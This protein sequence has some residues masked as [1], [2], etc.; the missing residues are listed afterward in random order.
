MKY[1]AEID[2]QPLEIEVRED[3]RVVVAGREIHADIRQGSRPEHF[4]L[5][6][7]GRSYQ[8]WME[9]VNGTLRVHLAG[10]DFEVR[11]EDERAHRLRQLAAPEASAHGAGEI[12]APMP[13]LVVKV[14]AEAGQEVKKGQGVVIVEAM[15]MENEI[16]SPVAGTVKE[17]RVKQRQAVE[18]GEVLIVVG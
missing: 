17:I 2:N 4:S 15:K 16:R 13:G 6:L 14:L 10:F 5:I 1:I 18:K 7:D 9:P 12:R 3:G 11:V 8:I